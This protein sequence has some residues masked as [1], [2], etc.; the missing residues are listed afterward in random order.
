MPTPLSDEAVNLLRI[1]ADGRTWTYDDLVS[2]LAPLIAPGK[3]I[4]RYRAGESYRATQV[5]PRIKAELSDARQIQ[6]GQRTIAREIIRNA[7]RRHVD[8][9]Q[10]PDGIML[11]LKEGVVP[12]DTRPFLSGPP[13]QKSVT[14]PADD[15]EPEA[16]PTIADKP[17]PI[18]RQCGLYIANLE[19]HED[20]HA[21]AGQP[22]PLP[23]RDDGHPVAFFSAAE[24]ADI[25]RAEVNDA[26]DNF[27]RGMQGW[28]VEQFDMLSYVQKAR[29]N[30]QRPRRVH[31]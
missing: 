30:G 10:T 14:E 7:L 2:A 20:F 6:S 19:Q 28:L 11:R 12:P 4:R 3:A 16:A 24:V 22:P 8:E 21:N 23:E 5:G 17:M 13:A 18:C 15:P 1:L 31:V 26:L 9:I 27:Q 25:V 29:T